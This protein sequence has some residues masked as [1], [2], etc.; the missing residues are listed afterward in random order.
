M[1]D[2]IEL[3]RLLQHLDRE[4]VRQ[5]ELAD[6]DLDIDAEIVFVAENLDHPAAGILRRRRPVGDLHFHDHAFQVAPL[7][8][9]S[10]L[11]ENAISV[12]LLCVRRLS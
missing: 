8:A 1:N 7:V 10:L 5:V 6:D 9:A 2:G 4:A 3:L 11:A 12:G